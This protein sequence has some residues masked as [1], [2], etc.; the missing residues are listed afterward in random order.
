MRDLPSNMKSSSH[1]TWQTSLSLKSLQIQNLQ[2]KSGGTWHITCPPYEKVEG[3]VLP[4]RHQI[5][6]MIF[7]M[8]LLISLDVC[9]S[10]R[11]L[12]SILD[13]WQAY[14][15]LNGII[16]RCR[17]TV[18]MTFKAKSAKSAVT[19]LLILGGQNR[20]FVNHYKYRCTGWGEKHFCPNLILFF[21]NNV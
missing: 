15:E 21:P 16:F 14:A 6:P 13:V 12:Q 19:S 10:V 4:V 20:R 3:H 8:F 2:R 11:W 17:K 18:C 7:A 9:W 5:A 1:K